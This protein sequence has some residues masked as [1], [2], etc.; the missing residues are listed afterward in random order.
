M[1]SKY[2][3]FDNIDI[4]DPIY[5]IKVLFDFRQK[6]S[7]YVHGHSA[8]GT[9]PSLVEMMHFNKS[10]FAFDCNYNRASTEGKA[11][12]FG[13]PEELVQLI[14]R[15]IDINNGSNMQEVA[16]RRYTWKIVKEQYFSLFK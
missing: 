5:D 7:F 1:K 10:I 12:Y 2:Q 9:N 14:N 3:Q 11:E 15:S 8:G 13:N 16:E 4:I 6:C